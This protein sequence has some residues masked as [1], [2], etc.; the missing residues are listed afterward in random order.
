MMSEMIREES[1][2][3]QMIRTSDSI[4][5]FDIDELASESHASGHASDLQLRQMRH[6]TRISLGDNSFMDIS[7]SSSDGEYDADDDLG[8]S[9]R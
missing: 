1:M 2:A 9:V 3:S 5:E 7:S 4:Y 6:G 8:T